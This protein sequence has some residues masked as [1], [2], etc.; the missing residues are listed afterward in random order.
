MLVCVDLFTKYSFVKPLRDAKAIKVVDFIEKEIFLTFGAPRTILVDNGPQYV[1]K[2]FAQ[3][4]ERYGVD[5]RY[6]IRYT[7]RNNPTE[8]YNQT[9]GTMIRSYCDENQR[10]WDKRIPEIQAALRTGVSEVTGYT[11]HF[12]VFGDELKLDGR[13]HLF[14]GNISEAEVEDRAVFV[15]TRQKRTELFE[16]VRKRMQ[17][18]HAKN[19]KYFDAR[20]RGAADF[21]VGM[22]VLRRNFALSD[23]QKGFS[24]KLADSW[25]GPFT[26]K[27]KTG[28]N[29]CLLEDEFGV[30]SGP[31]HLDQLKR[32]VDRIR[33]EARFRRGG[34][35]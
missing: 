7:P 29:T 20:R 24:S 21:P 10:T 13:E 14:D 33:R 19:K 32:Y 22:T 1:S 16:E 12:L 31:Y 18:A 9:L 35:L 28:D 8:R 17:S 4:C 23:A 15:A 5:R 30:E 11:P 26:I 27:K 34:D 2:E 25:V 6:N 3:M